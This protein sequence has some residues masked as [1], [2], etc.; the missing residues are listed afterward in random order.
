MSLSSKRKS[1][2]C[3]L[4]VLEVAEELAVEMEDKE[5]EVDA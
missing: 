3:R 2:Q 4:A 5:A 1:E